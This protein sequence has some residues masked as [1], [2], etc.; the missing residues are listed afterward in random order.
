MFG[1]QA[2]AVKS[3]VVILLVCTVVWVLY[4]FNFSIPK[5]N[6]KLEKYNKPKIQTSQT[7]PEKRLE[8]QTTDDIARKINETRN[9]LNQPISNSFIKNI[10]KQKV[11]EKL[12][13]KKPR[14]NIKFS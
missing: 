5:I 1:S 6:L 4:T 11:E 2:I 8:R 14:P 9:E 3:F 10:I 7:K 13:E 12:E